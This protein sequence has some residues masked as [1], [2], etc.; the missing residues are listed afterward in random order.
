MGRLS[1]IVAHHVPS[2]LQANRLLSWETNCIEDWETKVD[3]VVRETCT[4]DLRLVSGFHC[5]EMYFELLEHTGKRT[6]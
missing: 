1:G 4:E 6:V 3:A 2:Y 5:G